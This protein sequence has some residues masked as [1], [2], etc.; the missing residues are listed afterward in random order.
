MKL[1]KDVWLSDIFNYDVYRLDNLN[2]V[3]SVFELPKTKSFIWAKIPTERIG[4]VDLLSSM[5]FRVVD[6]NVTFEINKKYVKKEQNIYSNITEFSKEDETLILKIAESSFVYSRFH[7]DQYISNSLAERIK[8]MWIKN[9]IDKKRGV[10]LLV[11]KYE[12]EVAG[13]LAE[14]ESKHEDKSVGVID[15]ISID[16]NFQGKGLG[17]S[18]V[19]YWINDCTD[20]YDILRVGTQIAN[21]PSMRLYESCGF[22]ISNSLYIMHLHIK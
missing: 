2:E 10:R 18:L 7:L 12:D 1:I 5:N 11:I 4:L 6:V 20:K 19:D 21:I 3:D 17:K 14:I 8:K 13:F 9:Y 15:L 16:K 22:Q